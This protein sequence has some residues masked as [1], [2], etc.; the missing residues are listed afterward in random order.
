MLRYGLPPLGWFAMLAIVINQGMDL[1]W[2][3]APTES[4]MM[5]IGIMGHAFISTSLLAASFIY[6]PDL[7]TWI[8]SAQQWLKKQNTSSARA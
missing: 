5:C 4:W 6:Y 7:N 2:R 1:L 8:E 3:V